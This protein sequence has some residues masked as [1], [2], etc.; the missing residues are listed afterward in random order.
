MKSAMTLTAAVFALAISASSASAQRTGGGTIGCDPGLPTFQVSA[1][2]CR[3]FF[4]EALYGPAANPYASGWAHGDS[5]PIVRHRKVVHPS[6]APS[7][8]KSSVSGGTGN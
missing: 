7:A 3:L 6:K 5:A 1:T 4:K 2:N 8:R